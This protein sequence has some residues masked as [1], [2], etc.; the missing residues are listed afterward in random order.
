M[1]RAFHPA[2]LAVLLILAATALCG[3]GKSAPVHFYTLALEPAKDAQ[4]S[5]PCFSLGI[6]PVETPP[7]LD[8]SQIVTRGEGN[9][10][11]MADFDQWIEPV[12]AG[13]SRALGEALA[14]L[15][16]AGPVMSYPWPGGANPD[17]Q[18]AVQ[19]RSLDGTLGKEAVLRADWTITGKDGKVVAGK[20]SMLREPCGGPDFAS[21]VAAQSRLVDKLAREMA[22]ALPGGG[23]K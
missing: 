9:R 13:F 19:V 22:G 21:L 3:C 4:P 5:G 7:Y 11:L 10:M 1:S 8:R 20:S 2:R 12:Q 23:G 15:V 6:G 16:C 14:R 17:Y 18:V